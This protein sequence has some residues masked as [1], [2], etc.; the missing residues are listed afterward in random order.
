MVFWAYN[1]KGKTNETGGKNASLL[2]RMRSE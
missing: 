1:R 2:L